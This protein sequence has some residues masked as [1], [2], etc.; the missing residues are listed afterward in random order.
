M[1]DIGI[2]VDAHHA[3]Y[4]CKEKEVRVDY[5]KLRT[6]VPGKIKVATC[7]GQYNEDKVARFVDYIVRQGYTTHFMQ[8]TRQSTYLIKMAIDIVTSNFDTYVL[9]LGNGSMVPVVQYLKDN[10]KEVILVG[11]KVHKTLNELSDMTIDLEQYV[12]SNKVTE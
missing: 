3:Y 11:Y 6:C 1:K 12:V 5:S 8:D 4:L 10:C 7:Y 2:Y 9:V